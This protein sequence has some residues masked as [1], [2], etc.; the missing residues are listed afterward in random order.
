MMETTSLIIGYDFS[1][2]PCGRCCS[3][4][5]TDQVQDVREFPADSSGFAAG[6]GVRIRL[7]Y[8]VHEAAREVPH[9]VGLCITLLATNGFEI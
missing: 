2:M 5:T 4:P 7:L 9:R 8:P 6:L 1:T 3:N